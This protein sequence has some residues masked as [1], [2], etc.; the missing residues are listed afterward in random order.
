MSAHRSRLQLEL[1]VS[2]RELRAQP[3]HLVEEVLRTRLVESGFV[4]L[5]KLEI[6]EK[7]DHRCQKNA[8]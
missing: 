6:L 3:V 1:L 8:I 2:V 7:V 4:E 5:G